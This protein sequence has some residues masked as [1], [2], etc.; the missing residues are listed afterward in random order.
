MARPLRIL[1]PGAWYHVT[2]R[3]MERKIIFRDDRDRQHFLELLEAW[4]SRFR[5]RLH[6]FVLMD[7]HY[8]LLVETLEANLSSAMQWLNVS[9]SVWFN[10]RHQRVGYLLQGRFKAVLVE[11]QSWGLSLSAY[12]HLNPV[13]VGALGLSKAEQRG[14]KLG[15]GTPALPEVIQRR[16]ERLRTYRW[17]SYRFYAGYA[18]APSWLQ[19]E[20]INGLGGKTSQWALQY[21]AYVESAICEGLP[22][23]PWEEVVGGL[24][25]GGESFVQ[26]VK[27]LLERK[28]ASRLPRALVTRPGWKEVVQAVER[29]KGARWPEFCMAYGDWGRELAMYLGRIESGLS[30]AQLAET[31]QVGR[32]AVSMAIKRFQERLVREKPLRNALA[33]A[34]SYLQGPINVKCDKPTPGPCR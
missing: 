30:L 20:C 17:S 22:V 27:E 32:V 2:S 21:R 14:Q 5:C 11:P 12:L 13:R 23:A 19:T 6:A 28:P 7:N 1:Q 15:V 4:T 10:R 26:K 16:L 24:A 3:G 34:K 18:K 33:V 9:Y 8:H 25:L 29:V 31:G